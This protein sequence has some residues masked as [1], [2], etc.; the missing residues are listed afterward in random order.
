MTMCEHR[1]AKWKQMINDNSGLNVFCIRFL[2][3][4]LVNMSVGMISHFP[5]SWLAFI[6]G[7]LVSPS[8]EFVDLPGTSGTRLNIRIINLSTLGWQCLDREEVEHHPV[9]YSS[10]GLVY[11]RVCVWACLK[12]C[13]KTEPHL[14]SLLLLYYTALPNRYLN[15]FP[16]PYP[17]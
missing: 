6:Q 14:S 15:L 13:G 2:E 3:H 10:V 5:I 9:P 4:S 12:D 17:I 11:V 8:L 7:V 1:T 16:A